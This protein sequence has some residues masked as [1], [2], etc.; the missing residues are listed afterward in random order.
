M[1]SVVTLARGLGTEGTA[2]RRLRFGSRPGLSKVPTKPHSQG[3]ETGWALVWSRY[4]SSPPGVTRYRGSMILGKVRLW[5]S[6][7]L[8]QTS[9]RNLVFKFL[10]DLLYSKLG[11]DCWTIPRIFNTQP[12]SSLVHNKAQV[13]ESLSLGGDLEATGRGRKKSWREEWGDS[14]IEDMSRSES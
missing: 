12:C 9:Q 11:S 6:G 13:P 4:G 2:E 8:L 10:L 1:D 14:S 5:N 7:A 3:S